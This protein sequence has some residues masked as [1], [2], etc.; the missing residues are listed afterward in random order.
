MKSFTVS[1]PTKLFFGADKIEEFSAELSKIGTNVLIVTGG[2]SVK[3]FGFYDPVIK[4]FKQNGLNIFEFSGIEPNPVNSTI[5]LCA[6]EFSKSS[7]DM[8]LGFGGGSVMD[9]SK[10]ISALLFLYKTEG[11][12]G[13]YPKEIW[14]YVLG[15]SMANKLPGA[16]PLAMIPTTAATASEVTRSAVIS[17]LVAPGKASLGYEFFKPTASWLN[18]EFTRFLNNT[19]TADGASDILSHVFEN[20]L[21]GGDSSLFTDFYCEGIIKTVIQK[22]PQLLIDPTNLDLRSDLQWC[23][24]LALN[25]IHTAGRTPSI[26]ALHGIEHSMSALRHGLA[27]GRGLATLYPA[28]FRWL[29]NKDRARNRLTRLAVEIFQVTNSSGMGGLY[30]IEHFED[31]LR[32]NGLLQSA[33][34]LGF[35]Q[36]DYDWI[37]IYTIKTYGGGNPLDVL[38]PMTKSDIVEILKLTEI[39]K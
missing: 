25:G 5:D 22:L 10:A 11:S 24:C 19:V 30:F 29:W 8:V 20:Y 39:Q 17:N 3:K 31:W 38:G 12:N 4:I 27:H 34:D 35:S 14:P 1:I 21:L 32:S 6:K 9:A 18:P 23:A 7:I 26:Y 13:E 37:A 36:S 33:S 15:N 28:Y 16:L 2:G